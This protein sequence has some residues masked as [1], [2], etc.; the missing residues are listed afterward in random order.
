MMMMTFITQGGEGRGM[1]SRKEF[2]VVGMF[3]LVVTIR[4]QRRWSAA[5][6]QSPEARFFLRQCKVRRTE[7]SEALVVMPK[8]QQPAYSSWPIYVRVAPGTDIKTTSAHLQ[9][10]RPSG[11]TS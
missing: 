5:I 6:R 11:F 10:E 7:V 9:G 1:K 8:L 4:V 2:S 3:E